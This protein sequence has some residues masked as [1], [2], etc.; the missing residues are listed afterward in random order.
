MASYVML[1][2]VHTTQGQETIVFYCAH[3]SPRPGLVQCVSAMGRE[4]HCLYRTKMSLN[5]AFEM[6]A[7]LTLP[8]EKWHT[9]G[10]CVSVVKCHRDLLYLNSDCNQT[11]ELLWHLFQFLL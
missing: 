11:A 9:A 7:T 6:Q 3:P 1:C 2:I 4:D 5:S 8:S 10:A